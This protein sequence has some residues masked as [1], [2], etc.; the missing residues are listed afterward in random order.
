MVISYTMLSPTALLVSAETGSPETKTE[1]QQQEKTP[2]NT[3]VTMAEF[4][5]AT[6]FH[7]WLNN[8]GK[9]EEESLKDSGKSGVYQRINLRY[10]YAQGSTPIDS[11]DLYVEL[12][13]PKGVKPYYTKATGITYEQIDNANDTVIKVKWDALAGASASE[14]QVSFVAPNGTTGDGTKFDIPVN[15]VYNNQVSQKNKKTVTYTAIADYISWDAPKRMISSED[16][17]GTVNNSATFTWLAKDSRDIKKF[18]FYYDL[19]PKAQTTGMVYT[20]KVEFTDTIKVDDKVLIAPNDIVGTDG[21]V[22]KTTNR[23][24]GYVD[25]FTV[26]YSKE[27]ADKNKE[28]TFDKFPTVTIEKAKIDTSVDASV[29]VQ[30]VMKTTQFDGKAT[31]VAAVS[32]NGITD[33]SAVI[34]KSNLYIYQRVQ[35][36]QAEKSDASAQI[37]LYGKNENSNA[38]TVA[39]G[40]VYHFYWF[41]IANRQSA[42]V[43]NFKVTQK[44]DNKLFYPTHIKPG[45]FNSGTSNEYTDMTTFTVNFYDAD[46]NKLGSHTYDYKDLMTKP[47]GKNYKADTKVSILS[48]DGMGSVDLK[49]I[50]TIEYDFGTVP[51]KFQQQYA[52][53]FFCNIIKPAEEG[54]KANAEATVTYNY[55]GVNPKA[56]ATHPLQYQKIDF[57]KEDQVSLNK[58]FTNLTSP[59]VSHPVRGDLV[60]YEVTITNNSGRDLY[61]PEIEDCAEG[62]TFYQG[63]LDDKYGYKDINIKVSSPTDGTVEVAY[64]QCVVGKKLTN[65]KTG[66]FIKLTGPIK[67]GDTIT[68]KY[69]MKIDADLNS[70]DRIKNEFDAYAYPD[71]QGY[72]R[73]HI[74]SGYSYTRSSGNAVTPKLHYGTEII[75]KKS[76]GPI[77]QLNVDKYEYKTENAVAKGDAMTVSHTIENKK[78]SISTG[79]HAV[80]LQSVI[81]TIPKYKDTDSFKFSGKAT[82]TMPDGTTKQ[83]VITDV[84]DISNFDQ[85]Q[86]YIL[87]IDL[88]SIGGVTIAD[89]K[90]V[91]ITYD[92]TA[93]RAASDNSENGV[94]KVSVNSYYFFEDTAKGASAKLGFSGGSYGNLIDDKTE[95]DKDQTTQKYIEDKNATYLKR[96]PRPYA[97]GEITVGNVIDLSSNNHTRN[98][99]VRFYNY[100]D[101]GTKLELDKALAKIAVYETYKEGSAKVS[102]VQ[103]NNTVVNNKALSDVKHVNT[104]DGRKILSFSNLPQNAS[105]DNII[106]VDGDPGGN[107]YIQ[108][109]FTTEVTADDLPEAVKVTTA[110][111]GNFYDLNVQAAFYL[112]DNKEVYNTKI[113]QLT[114]VKDNAQDSDWDKETATVRRYDTTVT[115]AIFKYNAPTKPGTYIKPM[116]ILL[117]GNPV[118]ETY[119]GASAS[120]DFPPKSNMGF[121][122]SATNET[123]KELKNPTIVVVLPEGMEFVEFEHNNQPDEIKSVQTKEVNGRQVITFATKNLT[124]TNRG[125][126]TFNFKASTDKA[127]VGIHEADVYVVPMTLQE[128]FI[129]TYTTGEYTGSKKVEEMNL[130]TLTG[131]DEPEFDKNYMVVHNSTKLRVFGQ[132]AF[133]SYVTAK[134]GKNIAKSGEQL[135][136]ARNNEKVTYSLVFKN[137]SEEKVYENFVAINRLPGLNDTQVIHTDKRNSTL[138]KYLYKDGNIKVEIGGVQ[139]DPSKYAVEYTT[140]P[141]TQKFDE[142]DLKA[143]DGTIMWSDDYNSLNS[144]DITAFRV[145]FGKNTVIKAGET[146][147]IFYDATYNVDE[148]KLPK[149]NNIT[150]NSFAFGF[151]AIGS[152]VFN[153]A[154]PKAVAVKIK[155]SNNLNLYG[156]FFID[157]NQNGVYDQGV[158][159]IYTGTLEVSLYQLSADGKDEVLISTVATDGDKFPNG[160]YEFLDLKSEVDYKVVVK[161]PDRYNLSLS[162]DQ[163]GQSKLMA[164]PESLEEINKN[165]VRLQSNKILLDESDKSKAYATFSGPQGADT[166]VQI[167]GALAPVSG[168]VDGRVF[169]DNNKN[170]KYDKGDEFYKDTLTVTLKSKDGK[171]VKTAKTNKDGQFTFDNVGFTDYKVYVDLPKGYK[172]TQKST[173]FTNVNGVLTSKDIKLTTMDDAQSVQVGI[174]PEDVEDV[175][176]GDNSNMIV[177]V[178]LAVASL[179]LLVGVAA[180]RKRKTSKKKR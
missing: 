166:A 96:E 60:E 23:S 74:G 84:T 42:P 29:T 2:R 109:T 168:K 146:V 139:L 8:E 173:D 52:P 157:R 176:T 75:N 175:E 31:G 33:N 49:K 80:K 15:V 141:R 126:L 36:T 169:V 180:T 88:T 12:K 66:L 145:V 89:N 177:F 14:A 159:E 27:S 32:G 43:N 160:F 19:A 68:V 4:E 148:F 78:Y 143:N 91:T 77:Q 172:M 149:S 30:T 46:G 132:F 26:T 152:S 70:G 174:I 170:G 44:F 16:L 94:E 58:T 63:K 50:T 106:G 25:T 140:V 51:S 98:Y 164:T 47:D 138:N 39:E 13:F 100:S 130:K 10:T 133:S 116:K 135:E 136:V 167:D 122:V 57:D 6:T 134:D 124:L 162:A 40:Q 53:Y 62:Q 81:V 108:I 155:D 123:S 79:S 90:Q 97:G 22:I 163:A 127:F 161:I 5:K 178:F 112:K 156:G 99:T 73:V 179:I 61:H 20:G 121:Q 111:D 114:S 147:E 83:V 64:T 93:V 92:M 128:A 131:L 137:E 118:T 87:K 48:L 28:F 41:N 153:M 103:N 95:Y 119:T 24:D 65:G 129:D 104:I 105:A 125:N 7:V 38:N 120:E 54:Y 142:K 67:D 110:K 154:E 117:S 45:S 1:E 21:A 18:S 76:N 82:I 150:Y 11:K 113:N 86:N 85:T 115:S 144:D 9:T 151:N 3:P 17:S 102:Y 69:V 72:Q 107:S 37:R 158:D 56:T 101:Q 34:P 171:V 165:G 59:G 35:F 55:K 71:G